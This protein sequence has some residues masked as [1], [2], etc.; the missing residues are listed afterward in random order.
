MNSSN[1]GPGIRERLHSGRIELRTRI[2]MPPLATEKSINGAVSDELCDHYAVR[3]E[4]PLIGLIITE[5]MYVAPQGR[6]SK[7]QLSIADDSVIDGLKR[8]TDTIHSSGEDIK[9]FAQINHAGGKSTP[10]LAGEQ[11]V[12]S[13]AYAYKE[14]LCR[15]LR[16]DEIHCITELFIKA[17]RRAMLAGYDGVEIHSAHGYLLNQFYSPLINHRKDGYGPFS[18]ECRLR[19][20]REIIEGIR[21]E[22]GAGIPIAVRLGGCDYQEGGSNEEEA[23]EAS[24]LLCSY[25][26]DMIDVSG[27]MNGYIIPGHDYPGYFR[28]M[29]A[30]IKEAVSVP[31]LTTGGVTTADQA[32]ELLD[33]GAADLIGVGRA[34]LSDAAWG[35]R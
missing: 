9:V 24:R 10:E 33:I 35:C 30:A 1:T 26:A 18:L 16:E 4:N 13:S 23:V 19:L 29:S 31:V 34:L 8:L 15:G 20:H 25:G 14:G 32:Q 3:A 6:A 11:P 28:E 5:H 2:V 27:G 17:A 7:R 22:L 21:A 12:S